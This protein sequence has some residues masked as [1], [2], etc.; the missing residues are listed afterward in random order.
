MSDAIFHPLDA[1]PWEN[2]DD[3]PEELREL[4]E[5]AK[6]VGARRAQVTTGAIGLHTQLSEMPAGYEV[7]P[8]RHS[9][10]ELMVVLEGGCTIANGPTLTAGDMAEVPAD[11]EY[12]F[13]VGPD[14][15]RFIVVRPDKSTTKLS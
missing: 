13:T 6:A 14:G 15:M 5:K 9:A 11:S 8:H 4:A 10:H 12:G 3:A 1:A 7:P 2:P